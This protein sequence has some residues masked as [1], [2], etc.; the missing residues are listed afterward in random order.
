MALRIFNTLTRTKEDFE[1]VVAGRV[2]MYCCGPTVYSE[3]HIGHMVGPVVCDAVKR[4]L[5]Y[6]G[7]QVTLV[8]N[9]TDVDDKIIVQAAK[10]GVGTDEL[11]ARVTADY[12]GALRE[13]AV[14]VDHFPHATQYVAKMI[15]MIQTLVD[16][17][18]AYPAAGDV[19]F[20]VAKDAD[21]G[22]LSNQRTDAMLSSGRVEASDRKRGPADFALWKAAKPGEPSWDSPW[23][24]GRPGWHIEC[25]A[26]SRDLLGDTFDIHAGGLDLCFPHHENELAQSES[27]NGKPFAK[28]W[29]HNGLLQATGA[30]FKLG[31]AQD[32]SQADDA[33]DA[34]AAGDQAAQEAG[35]MSKSVGNTI[36]VRN[37]IDTHGAQTIRFFLLSTHYRSPI[38]FSTEALENAGKAVARVHTFAGRV[39]R[40]TGISFYELDPPGNRQPPAEN[41]GDLHGRMGELRRDFLRHMDD[42]FNTG[43]AV[44]V[45]FEMLPL[46]NRFADDHALE[47]DRADRGRVAEFHDAVRILREVTAAVGLFTAPPIDASAGGDALTP[48]LLDLFLEVRQEARAAKQYALG[49]LIRD[50]LADLGVTVQDR[51][52]GTEW[53]L[54]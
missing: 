48:K 31:G 54:Q 15:A 35:K 23:G 26:M 44:G 38:P 20:E 2:G 40:I 29:M 25:S 32:R 5:A 28:Y 12:Q 52:G 45:V 37:L 30:E 27:C 51:P 8:I 43:G 13:L 49:D 3:S 39:Q 46:L 22:K 6:S 53:S 33:S 16:K 47:S 24:A 18:F 41:R 50:R 9:V 7:F 34:P 21:Y 42:D 4:Y 10:E 19:Y 17:G 14:E 36:L 11:T 1:P